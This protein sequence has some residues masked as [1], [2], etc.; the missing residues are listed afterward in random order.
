MIPDWL[1]DAALVPLA[2]LLGAALLML[3]ITSSA[4]FASLIFRQDAWKAITLPARSH[5]G[6]KLSEKFTPPSVS[7]VLCI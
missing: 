4:S 1:P 6:V 5:T 3:V 2:P 7:S